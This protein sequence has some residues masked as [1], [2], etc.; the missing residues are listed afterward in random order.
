MKSLNKSATKTFRAI[1]ERLNGSDACTI[2]NG[3]SFMALHVDRLQAV[4]AGTIYSLA[5]YFKQNGDMCCDPDMTFLAS[6]TGTAMGR[7]ELDGVYALTFQQA[8]PPIYQD[9]VEWDGPKIQ[10]VR[11]KMQADHTRFANTW[12]RNIREQQGLEVKAVSH[13]K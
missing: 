3:G 10:G 12:L 8:I 1:I 2:D 11:L 13:A 6:N 4:E 7:P 9:A 5:H